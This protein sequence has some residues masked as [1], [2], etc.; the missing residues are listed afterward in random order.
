MRLPSLHRAL[1]ALGLMLWWPLAAFAQSN[2]PFLWQVRHGTTTHYLLGSVHLLPSAALPLP[3][4]L[5]DAYET[6]SGILLETDLAAL[7][8]PQTQAD[9][10]N[11]AQTP[12][13]LEAAIGH[14]LFRRLSARLQAMNIPVET[15][16]APYKAW[17]C[18][19][20]LEALSFSKDGFDPTNGI[21]QQFYWQAQRDD[22]TVGWLEEPADHLALFTQMPDA[23]G[24]EFLDSTLDELDDTKQS[25][26]TLFEYWRNNDVAAIERITAQMKRQQPRLYA[27]LLANRTRAWLPSLK[28]TLDGDAPQLI[29]VGAAHLVGPD[30][31]VQL[32][33]K[34]G[35]DV[36]P[37]QPPTAE[38]K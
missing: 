10:L 19:M 14:T 17:F 5:E 22:K 4:A 1:F 6:T 15:S 29:I 36:S 30:G 18:A 31:L 12:K 11:A 20:T 32:L 9:L 27:R 7:E 33:R 16:C 38:N 34:A 13:G 21:D 2:A 3:A 26:Q 35:Y 37:M 24:T 28:A 25:P 8:D 23:M